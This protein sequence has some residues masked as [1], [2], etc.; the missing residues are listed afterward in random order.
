MARQGLTQHRKFLSLSERLDE[1]FPGFGVLLARGALELLWEP[2]YEAG[3]DV[4]GFSADVERRA[5]WKGPAG[6]LTAA[7]EA[8]GGPGFPGFIE[9]H[10][11]LDGIYVI[12]DLFDH[13]PEYVVKRWEKERKR[14]DRAEALRS[15]RAEAGRKGGLAR[16]AKARQ[17][18]SETEE[19]PDTCKQNPSKPKQTQANENLPSGKPKQTSSTQHSAL[20]EDFA[21]FAK[22]STGVAGPQGG[23][24][25]Q[26]SLT[27][28]Q[29]GQESAAAVGGEPEPAAKPPRALAAD[30]AALRDALVNEAPGRV[31][32]SGEPT[33]P[34][35]IRIRSYRITVIEASIL[36]SWLAAGGEHFPMKGAAVL[37]WKLLAQAGDDL[38]AQ[39]VAWQRNGS[40]ALSRASPGQA[41]QS[42]RRGDLLESTQHP[43][44][45][46]QL[47]KIF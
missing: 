17:N 43:E 38:R 20:R 42:R 2:A 14:K 33:K 23:E 15:A 35:A 13:A 25:G 19:D 6:E 47:A 39:A 5:H 32:L 34:Q 16:A 3:D 24:V 36:G 30:L 4:V 7:L 37:S 22:Q 40:P 44:T 1:L 21:C 27:G 31:E 9:P 18:E 12:H 29:D 46:R 45:E 26:L 8:A 28:E 10:P 41:Q 11:E